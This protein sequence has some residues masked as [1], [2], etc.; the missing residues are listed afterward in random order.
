MDPVSIYDRVRLMA[1]SAARVTDPDTIPGNVHVALEPGRWRADPAA[2]STDH[3]IKFEQ[4]SRLRA[5]TRGFLTVAFTRFI[6]DS[7]V[8]VNDLLD[9]AFNEER[10][11]PGWTELSI[12]RGPITARTAGSTLQTGMFPDCSGEQRFSATKHVLYQRG[13]VA[14]LL[15][16]R[17]WTSSADDHERAALTRVVESVWLED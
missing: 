11:R 5:R 15:D 7:G 10:R 4:R 12:E 16:C 9:D 3:L 13:N 8:A 6:V 1:V 14:S 17:G 2:A